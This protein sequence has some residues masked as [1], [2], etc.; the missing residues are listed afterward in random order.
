LI[1]SFSN[2][3]ITFQGVSPMLSRIKYRALL[4][5]GVITASLLTA[6]DSQPPAAAAGPVEVGVVTVS[7]SDA[8]LVADLPGRTTAF[9]RAEVRPQ[10]S[11]IIQK[12]LFEEGAEIEAGTRL[13]Q[14][15]SA[16]YQ[17]ALAT[18]QAELARAEANIAAAEAREARY[19]DL[20]GAK[21]ISQQ[22]Y[23]DALAALRSE[24]HTSE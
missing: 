20:V 2:S 7:A 24:E 17:A 21:A 9:R 23:D 13:Y 3:W 15:D 5:L 4:A 16:T 8:P 11:G 14:I 18:A 22:D 12:R 10:V 1:S 19:K 6:C